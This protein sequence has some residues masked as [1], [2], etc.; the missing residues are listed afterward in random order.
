MALTW[1]LGTFLAF[2]KTPGS[3][4]GSAAVFLLGKARKC[5]ATLE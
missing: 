3:T 1:L 2:V 5:F 4:H